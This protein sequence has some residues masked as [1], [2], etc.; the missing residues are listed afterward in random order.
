MAW[1]LKI[2]DCYRSVMTHP[3]NVKRGEWMEKLKAIALTRKALQIGAKGP[4]IGTTWTSMDLYDER[5]CIDL[6]GHDICNAQQMRPYWGRWFVIVCNAVLEHV[7]WPF[8][9]A[10]NLTNML[11][12]DGIL[13]AEVPFI[14]PYHPHGTY[15]LSEGLL[16]DD[17][18]QSK[19]HGGDYWRFTPQGI[20]QLFHR[21]EVLDLFLAN[22]GG[23]VFVGHKPAGA[24]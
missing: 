13:Y 6:K 16:V 23:V 9:A 1:D 20:R 3:D 19:R 5:E 14:Q 21:L 22:E 11:A 8:Q 17:A 24:P 2:M 10:D 4:K 15:Q 18:G 7:C 12:P